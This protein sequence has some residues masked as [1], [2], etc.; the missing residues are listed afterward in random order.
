MKE[1]RNSDPRD[2]ERSRNRWRLM[3]VGMVCAAAG[4]ILMGGT[5]T[6]TKPSE[7]A[8]EMQDSPRQGD[9]GFVGVVLDPTKGSGRWASTLLAIKGDGEIFYLDTSR[10]ETKWVRYMYS[11][12]SSE[13]R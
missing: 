3:V 4:A 7:S 12:G 13:R 6:G 8:H 9:H 10:P 11:P 2:L 1:S 5:E